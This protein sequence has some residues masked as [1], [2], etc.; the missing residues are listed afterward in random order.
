[1]SLKA[2]R[3]GRLRAIPRAAGACV[4]AVG[5]GASTPPKMTCTVSGLGETEAVL[6]L[7]HAK[8][9]V[10]DFSYYMSGPVGTSVHECL[11]K[12]QRKRTTDRENLERGI[13]RSIW[14]D[15]REGTRVATVDDP[16]AD[17]LLMFASRPDGLRLTFLGDSYCGTRFQLPQ[18]IEFRWKGGAC[19]GRAIGWPRE[20]N[21]AFYS[22]TPRP[23]AR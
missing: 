2:P 22:R 21:P 8:R 19:H 4:I 1:M 11:I 17:H 13:S 6:T 12:A 3:P 5:L 16:T 9:R 7:T 10:D 20:R 14:S 23:P 15:T 18:A